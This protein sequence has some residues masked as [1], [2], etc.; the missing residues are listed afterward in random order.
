MNDSKLCI[1]NVHTLLQ[2]AET[3]L[4]LNQEVDG[5]NKS[6]NLNEKIPHIKCT[7]SI[8]PYIKNLSHGPRF[9]SSQLV[10]AQMRK[11]ANGITV[12][13]DPVHTH[14]KE[15][16]IKSTAGPD[17]FDLPRT[18]L[19]PEL[20]RD[21]QLIQM[22][23]VL[24]PKRHYKKDKNRGKIPEYSQVGTVIQGPTEYLSSRLTNRERKRTLLE[25]VLNSEKQSGRFKKK[26]TEIQNAKTSGKKSHYRKL[27]ESRTKSSISK[28]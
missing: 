9:D 12:V 22:R 13:T 15:K 19:T 10:P 23:D 6:S 24:D 26:Y 14:T 17:W 21:L 5:S 3:R 28:R 27:K 7:N 2:D 4:R 16:D 11:S 25:E 8:Q 20:K 18:K 1:E